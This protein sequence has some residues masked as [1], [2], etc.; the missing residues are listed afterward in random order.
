MKIRFSLPHDSQ[1]ELKIYD[2][3]GREV[4]TLVDGALQASDNHVVT[5]Y[6]KNDEGRDVASGVYFYRLETKKETATKKM[7][8]LR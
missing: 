1:V 8:L 5:W 6:G 2:I 7:V 3:T 4:R